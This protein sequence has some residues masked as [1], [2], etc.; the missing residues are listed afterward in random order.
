MGAGAKPHRSRTEEKLAAILNICRR[1][2]S[3]RD[4]NTL[5]DLVAV[6]AA[7]LMEAERA[8][9]FLLDESRQVLSSKVALGS[10]EVLRFD[11]RLGVAGAV[12]M[13]GETI[14]V[15]DAYSDPRFYQQVDRQ[16]GYRTRNLLAVPLR[17][18]EG[19]ILGA[20]E[21][22]NKADGPFTAE[23]E[24]ILNSLAANAAI[25]IQTARL[26]AELRS[27]RQQLVAENRELRRE[28]ESR[29]STGMILGTS[30]K[31]QAML[32]LIERVRTTSVGVLITGESGT[33]KDLVARA[34]HYGSPRAGGPFVALNCA[35][36]PE[37]LVETELFGVE[38]G[39]A[40]GV[41]RRV[42]RFE[43]AHGGTIFLDEIGDLSLVAQAKILRALQERAVER[44]GGRQ[45][46]PV[47]VRVIA[48]TN[49]DLEGEIRKGNFRE[50]LYYRLNVVH[51]RTPSLREIPGDILLLAHH[52]LAAACREMEREP[53]TFSPA[54]LERLSRF[55]W[56][57]NVRQ[58]Q[59]E[60][61]RM[62]VCSRGPVIGVEDLAGGPMEAASSWQPAGEVA[63]EPAGSLPEEIE[64]LERKRIVEALEAHNFNQQRT[65]R[66]L[67]LSRQ[68]LINK[69][70]R[71]G[72]AT[73]R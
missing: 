61:Q 8:S 45:A 16:T 69:L 57:G 41:D 51:V 25:A 55:N 27:H 12:A 65:A 71:Y 5:L 40:T 60:I 23:D 11:A 39:V 67:G 46:I 37:T 32:R 4:L 42:G 22:L 44:I 50:D 54:V 15:A 58:L 14:N 34:V 26:I 56:P 63:S 24:E 73:S 53:M 64:R 9:I 19:E 6:E 30:E 31:I 52:F 10:D 28:V 62:A 17:D 68:G 49:K 33:G 21:V 7:R 35:A 13:S 2:N 20:F 43:A 72:I 18:F 47:D 48:A 66:A 3:E 38:K 36:L 1:M 29:F 70:K 59:N